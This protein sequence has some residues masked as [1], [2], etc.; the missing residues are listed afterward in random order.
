M[1]FVSRAVFIYLFL[2]N[3]LTCK[4]MRVGTGYWFP[5]A[6]YFSLKGYVKG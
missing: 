2:S 4:G 3:R 1:R 5:R 6:V